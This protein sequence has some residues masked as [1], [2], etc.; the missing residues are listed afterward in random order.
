MDL[1]FPHH[2]S[3]ADIAV[4]SLLLEQMPLYENTTDGGTESH[5]VAVVKL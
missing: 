4:L 2:M 3:E 5:G 1:F